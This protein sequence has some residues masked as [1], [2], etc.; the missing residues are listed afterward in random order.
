MPDV[1]KVENATRKHEPDPRSNGEKD[2]EKSKR[3]FDMLDDQYS[4]SIL[5]WDGF[6]RMELILVVPHVVRTVYTYFFLHCHR[7]TGIQCV[8]WLLASAMTSGCKARRA[9]D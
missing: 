5:H 9:R 1:A 4:L 7:H 8:W 3:C 2:G 6:V